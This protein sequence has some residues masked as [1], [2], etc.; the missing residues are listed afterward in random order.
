VLLRDPG[1]VAA[2]EQVAAEGWEEAARNHALGALAALCGRQARPPASPPDTTQ[3]KHIMMS[4]Q[5][6]MQHV[7]KNIVKELQLRGFRTWFD[8]ENLKGSTIDAMSDAVEHS[9]VRPVVRGHILVG[10]LWDEHVGVGVR[11]H[12]ESF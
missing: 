10:D 12:S 2:L 6:N 1:I 9:E 3:Q 7:V 11:V 8:I 4:Y 5:W